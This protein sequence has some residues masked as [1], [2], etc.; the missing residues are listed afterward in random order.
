MID[1]VF[2]VDDDFPTN[3]Y[4]EIVGKKS[5]LV[6]KMT[7]F[8]SARKALSYF[9]EIHNGKDLE[10]PQVLFLDLNMPEI[11]GWDFLDRF[12]EFDLLHRPV[13]YILSTTISRVD[14]KRFADDPLVQDAFQKPL[15]EDLLL[16][17]LERT[18]VML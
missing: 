11:N 6:G 8:L 1:H 3:F 7:S 14:E 10:I 15:T 16:E 13:I 17:I 18:N 4:H 2:F 9:E 12:R 5:G